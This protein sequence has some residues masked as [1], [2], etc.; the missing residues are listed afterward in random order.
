MTV[1]TEQKPKKSLPLEKP[2]EDQTKAGSLFFFRSWNQGI[3]VSFT[4]KITSLI[5]LVVLTLEAC[6]TRGHR[7]T[8]GAVRM[9][10]GENME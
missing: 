8:S 10:G 7:A 4:S 1:F 6:T 9:I 3:S 2:K 5:N